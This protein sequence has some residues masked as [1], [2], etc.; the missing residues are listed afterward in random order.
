VCLG[1]SV[2]SE[3]EGLATIKENLGYKRLINGDKNRRLK[4]RHCKKLNVR[5]Y[6]YNYESEVKTQQF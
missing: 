6:S 3:K 4:I 5:A 2:K 1:V